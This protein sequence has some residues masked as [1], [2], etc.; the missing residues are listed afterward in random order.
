MMRRNTILFAGGF[1]LSFQRSLFSKFRW[2]LQ[3]MLLKLFTRIVFESPSVQI[4]YG[5][6]SYRKKSV[7]NGHLFVDETKFTVVKKWEDRKFDFGFIGAFASEKG[8]VPFIQTCSSLKDEEYKIII[9][10]KGILEKY[11]MTEIQ[12][13]NL[14][15]VEIIAHV[16]YS[17]MPEL[18]NELKLLVVP[19]KRE[20]LPNVV[21]EAMACGTPV[22]AAP[23]GG[24][25]DVIVDSKTGVVLKSI[26]P[27][28]MGIQIRNLL[29]NHQLLQKVS[30]NARK[31]ITQKFRFEIAKE[32]WKKIISE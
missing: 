25:P 12:D 24:I 22:L 11:V 27:L 16:E 5:L 20:G 8:I 23:V 19:S 13:N 10:G 9:I 30:K 28:E 18:F 31:L 26:N 6:N 1:D 32:N 29:T 21:I 17:K 2:L 7:T 4:F 3:K 14:D 15:L